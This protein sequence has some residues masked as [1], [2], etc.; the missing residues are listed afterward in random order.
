[1]TATTTH[2]ASA[3]SATPTMDKTEMTVRNPLLV[4]RTCLAA[5][6]DMKPPRSSASSAY[7]MASADKPTT[8][9]MPQTTVLT[10]MT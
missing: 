9:T 10:L 5:T 3:D 6:N 8:K 4:A 1:M 2:S 7:G